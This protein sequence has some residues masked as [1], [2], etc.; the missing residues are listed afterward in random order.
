MKMAGGR[1]G[2]GSVKASSPVTTVSGLRMLAVHGAHSLACFRKLD[3]VSWVCVSSL[4]VE[5][6]TQAIDNPLHEAAKRGMFD[7][8]CSSTN[9]INGYCVF[10][11]TGNLPFLQECVSNRVRPCPASTTITLSS[12][13]SR[14]PCVPSLHSLEYSCDPFLHLHV[15]H[16]PPLSTP[17][18]YII[19]S[20]LTWLLSYAP[21]LLSHDCHVIPPQVSVNGLDKSGSTALHWAASGGHLGEYYASPQHIIWFSISSCVY[22][23]W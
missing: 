3:W 4:S 21:S 23:L 8:L 12:V 2:V 13:S 15:Y 19:P 11:F 6:S 16:V 18:R 1:A 9:C 5:S 10:A 22:L 7:A 17:D 20:P 14:L